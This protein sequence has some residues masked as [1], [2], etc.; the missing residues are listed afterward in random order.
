MRVT[1]AV[2]LLGVATIAVLLA[3]PTQSPALLSVS[4]VAA[5]VLGWAALRIVWTEVLQSR[6][7]NAADRAAAA[8]AYRSLFSERAAEHAEFTTEMTERLAASNLSVRELQGALVQSQQVAAAEKLRAETATA[9]LAKTEQRVT[10]LETNIELLRAENEEFARGAQ[11]VEDLV[12][13]DEKVAQAVKGED[14]KAK[15]A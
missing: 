13:F 9:A 11:E 15:L 2:A 5:V 8:N 6:R 4:S 12:A 3:L 1:V 7:E 14:K 10:E